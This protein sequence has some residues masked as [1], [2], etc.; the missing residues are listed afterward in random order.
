MQDNLVIQDEPL[1]LIIIKKITLIMVMHIRCV[2][3]L[4]LSWEKR[5]PIVL[6]MLKFW[7]TQGAAI[8]LPNNQLSLPAS[9]RDSLG[10]RALFWRMFY[11][12]ILRGGHQQVSNKPSNMQ[13]VSSLLEL[14]QKKQPFGS[15]KMFYL[16]I[17]CTHTDWEMDKV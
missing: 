1:T 11:T 4:A 3:V 16:W 10:G 8:P 17:V 6:D 12:L 7:L 5:I 13:H 15:P 9:H 2:P 14:L